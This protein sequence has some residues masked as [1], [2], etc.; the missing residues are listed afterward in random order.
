MSEDLE[1]I[2]F[3]SIFGLTL[4]IVAFFFVF[5]MTVKNDMCKDLGLR[6]FQ[7]ELSWVECA[8]L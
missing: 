8:V 5:F 7:R 2:I 3:I 6:V 4:A 1:Y